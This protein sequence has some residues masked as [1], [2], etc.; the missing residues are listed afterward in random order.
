M[1]D[2]PQ[3]KLSSYID[4]SALELAERENVP[5]TAVALSLMQ[6]SLWI[7]TEKHGP[8][9]V[10]AWLDRE[11]KAYRKAIKKNPALVHTAGNA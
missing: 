11:A 3:L 9:V 10:S 8:G 6:A 5:I 1:T 4:D 7:F 2:D